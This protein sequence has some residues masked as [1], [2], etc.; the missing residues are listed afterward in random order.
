MKINWNFL[1]EGGAKKNFPWE[2]YGY[3]LE[4][5]N[6]KYSQAEDL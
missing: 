1:G 5:H 4:L 2:E 6:R 3:F